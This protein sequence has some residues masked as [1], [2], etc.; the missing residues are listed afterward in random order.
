MKYNPDK[1]HRRSIRL[2]GYDYAQSGAYFVT[3]CTR[4][5]ELYFEDAAIKS[6]AMDCWLTLPDHF[7][8][9]M[10]DEFVV[11]PNHVHGL[12]VLSSRVSVGAQNFE[13]LRN[14]YQ[15][16]IPKSLGSIIRTYKSAVTTWCRNNDH[17]YFGWQRNYHERIIR[18]E[19][20]LNEVRQYITNNP[21]RWEEDE[22]H[23]GIVREALK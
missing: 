21:I 14:T 12:L 3:I 18:S 17:D 16:I 2:K 11:M 8:N 6:A 19:P 9:A 22:N 4:E 10:L 20:E 7:P 5:K 13:P 23:P 1:H 15:H